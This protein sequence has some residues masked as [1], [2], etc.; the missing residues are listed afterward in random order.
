MSEAR[1]SRVWI[2]VAAVAA[3]ALGVR[4]A[5][6][7]HPPHFDEFYH[8]LAARSWLADGT[9]A[10]GEGVYRRT[11]PFTWLV[12][13]SMGLLGDS[14]EA[15]RIP[16]V[17]AGTLWVVIVFVWARAAAGPA[18]AWIS[19]AFMCFDPGMVNLSQIARFY[20]VQG[21][22]FAAGAASFYFLAYRWDH[23][24]RRAILAATAALSLLLALYFQP[25][26]AIGIAALG[27]WLV[28][29]RGPGAVR[30]AW[31][32][33]RYRAALAAAVVVVLM[34]AVAAVSA[35]LMDDAW[36][37]YRGAATWAE[38]NQNN[39]LWYVSWF[40]AR[41]ALLWGLLPL[42]ALLAFAHYPAPAGFAIVVFGVSFLLQS[43]G[44]FKEE[45]YLYYAMPFFFVIWAIA[46][47]AVVPYLWDRAA[48]AAERLNRDL[49]LRFSLKPVIGVMLGLALL[50]LAYYNDAVSNG[51]RMLVPD[52]QRPYDEADWEPALPALNSHLDAETVIVSSAYV[53]AVYYLGRAHVGLS[54]T[55]RE[56]IPE[57]F[58]FGRDPRSGIRL[59]SEPES[60]ERLTRCEPRGLVIVEELHWARH[61][62][63][64]T[65]AAEFL[66]RELEPVELP[67]GT[68]LRAFVWRSDEASSAEN[69]P[70]LAP[71]ESR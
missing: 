9:L 8:I 3:V 15:A 38:A 29:L 67:A 30:L 35:G 11:A 55:Q 59:V 43:F 66:T 53:K 60:L 25:T 51:V 22:C 34:V 45:R 26:S 46:A 56:E 42:A 19:A 17:L 13:V 12:G 33:P 57:D 40:E 54:R 61:W 36:Q 71:V 20:S 10:I 62:A 4:L 50:P 14:I 6:L 65:A 47:V 63:V 49:R 7:G 68:D 64:D 52:G 16:S 18:A 28:S 21:A 24:R 39:P 1:P 69:C 41:W 5:W 32:S 48:I 27:V 23:P 31:H 37:R 70:V 44:G 58:E 2:E